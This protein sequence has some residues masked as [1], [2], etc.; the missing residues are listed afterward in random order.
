VTGPENGTQFWSGDDSG[1][2]FSGNYANWATGEPNDAGGEDCAQFLSGGTGEWNDLPCSGVD[3]PGYV[4]EFGAAGDMPTV[5]AHEI[6]LATV[7]TPSINTLVPAD[8]AT[9]VDG[10]ANLVITFSETVTV[11]TGSVDVY[12][13]SDVELIESIPVT[14]AQV[15]GSGSNTITIDPNN[16]LPD[17]TDWYV[18]IASTAFENANNIFFLGIED[19]TT[20]SFTTGDYTGPTFSSIDVTPQRNSVVLTWVTN[21]HTSTQVAYGDDSTIDQVTSEINT[22]PRVTNHSVTLSDL[23]SCTNYSYRISGVDGSVNSNSA[24]SSVQ[25]FKTTGCSSGVGTRFIQRESVAR[26]PAGETETSRLQNIWDEEGIVNAVNQIRSEPNLAAAEP[27]VAL[28]I[29]R[30]YVEQLQGQVNTPGQAVMRAPVRDL[31]IGMS[32]NDVRLLQELLINVD[33]GPAAAEL[34]RVGATAYF[35]TYTKNALGEYQQ[36]N[37]IVPFSGYFGPITRTQ[38]EQSRVADLWW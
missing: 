8:N 33:T 21:E 13:A 16:D 31:F 25:T 1:S 34:A 10:A 22:S 2:A 23:T 37:D 20:W 35:G 27:A 19:G 28:E 6:A 38:I 9:N 26:E 36:M 5:I 12:R 14:S 29:L 15:T 3:L 18:Q 30:T 11:G 24:T 17:E 32:G 7:N 4:V